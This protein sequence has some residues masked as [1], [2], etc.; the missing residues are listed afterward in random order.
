MVAD[1]VVD[2]ASGPGAYEVELVNGAIV[3]TRFG[4]GSSFQ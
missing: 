4:V 2:P 1:P 3:E